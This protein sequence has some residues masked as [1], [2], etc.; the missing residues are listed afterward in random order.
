MASLLIT[1]F[2]LTDLNNGQVLGVDEP[3]MPG[4]S[5]KITVH[6]QGEWINNNDNIQSDC[7]WDDSS[8][9]ITDWPYGSSGDIT[10][11][12]GTH[13]LLTPTLITGNS[14]TNTFNK[15]SIANG[16]SLIFSDED[17]SVYVCEIFNEGNLRIGGPSCRIQNNIHIIFYGTISDSSLNNNDR[18]KTSKG[19]ISDGNSVFDLFGKKYHPT[20]TRLAYIGNENDNSITLQDTTNWEIGQEIMI[21]TTIWFDCP[22]FYELEWCLQCY[23]WEK[24]YYPDKYCLSENLISHQNEVRVI[25]NINGKI[26]TLNES[27]NY[28]HYAGKEYQAEVVLLSR[29]ILLEGDMLDGTSFDNGFG[30]HTLATG[31]TVVRIAGTQANNMGQLN[32][33][34]RYPLHMHL[35][36]NGTDSYFTDNSVTNSFFR[37]YVIHGTNDTLLSRNIAYN[38]MGMCYYI[39][40]G[41]EEN[42]TLSYNFAGHIH[43]I[44]TPSGPRGGQSGYNHETVTGL[45][46][47]AL[48]VPVDTSASGFYISNAYNIIRGNAASGGWSGFAFPN[49]PYPLGFW[50]GDDL[51]NNNPL[52]RPTLVFDGNTAHSSGFYWHDHG[53]CMYCGAWL[54][55]ETSDDPPTFTYK[56]GRERRQ[57]KDSDGNEQWMIFEN[58][59][60]FLCQRG[61]THWGSQI[62]VY[63]FEA[64]DVW[65]G[66]EIFGEAGISN[67]IICG[68]SGNENGWLS[69][70]GILYGYR[71]GFRGYDTSV[72]TILN[73]ITFR[74]YTM[75]QYNIE[76]NQEVDSYAYQYLIGSDHY[77]PQGIN[78]VN[79]ITF[80]NCD[81]KS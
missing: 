73:S 3:V 24:D 79:D 28:Q 67:G 38:V 33:L 7:P 81:D 71:A 30:G 37:C 34:G 15:I 51:G 29:N 17:I 32:V 13:V 69:T 75:S 46:F 63:G 9:T 10:I 48:A 4:Y 6:T 2:V 26:I 74:N 47:D 5:E 42:N 21:T 35:L 76:S 23:S 22:D 68:R 60:T 59:K 31:N 27:L 36:G 25:N 78:A 65:R 77:I 16:A 54:V 58:V 72:K 50:H 80:E 19:I 11:P 55:Q 49:I 12:S 62:E 70:E 1:L 57:T 53:G 14:A 39:E 56:S 64:Y 8:I 52:N 20:W 40:D 18:S 66:A 44:Y 61:I 45:G 43:P 41:I